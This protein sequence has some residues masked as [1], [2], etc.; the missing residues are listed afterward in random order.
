MYDIQFSDLIKWHK[1]ITQNKKASSCDYYIP[2]IIKDIS[3]TIKNAPKKY[4]S[5]YYQLKVEHGAVGTFLIKIEAK[6][7]SEYWQCRASQQIVEYLYA[8]YQKQKKQKRKLVCKLE[9]VDVKWQP[10]VE[11]RQLAIML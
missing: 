1:S 11:K 8:R 7:I 4:A 5:R 10:Q 9:K 3:L 2:R 6:K